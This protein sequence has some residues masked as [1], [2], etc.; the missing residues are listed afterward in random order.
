EKYGNRSAGVS[1]YSQTNIQTTGETPEGRVEVS[2]ERQAM[3]R[4]IRS[5]ILGAYPEAAART[6]P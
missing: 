1:I 3:L 5:I 4:R 6:E 2:P